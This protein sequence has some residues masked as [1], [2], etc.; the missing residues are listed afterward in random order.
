ML[1]LRTGR[2][3]PTEKYCELSVY[4]YF[5]WAWIRS[6]F[7]G[8]FSV[9]PVYNPQNI[10]NV[11]FCCFQ[12][13]EA[14]FRNNDSFFLSAK[15]ELILEKYTEWKHHRVEIFVLFPFISLIRVFMTMHLWWSWLCTHIILRRWKK[16][17]IGNTNNRKRERQTILQDGHIYCS[18]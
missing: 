11:P 16:K 2:E 3:R 15:L 6:N 12:F 1:M 18:S 7:S 8:F 14:S 17:K 10:W 5:Q 13:K 9:S 4:Y